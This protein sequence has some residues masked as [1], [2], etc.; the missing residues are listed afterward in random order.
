MLAFL[1][2]THRPVKRT[3]YAHLRQVL[4]GIT[5]GA[6]A[7][8]RDMALRCVADL[9]AINAALESALES[10]IRAN[11]GARHSV[12]ERERKAQE[13]DRKTA[14]LQV[15]GRAHLRWWMWWWW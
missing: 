8:S 11:D 13:Q 2:D 3:R 6:V 1:T 5:P 12:E 15:Y 4:A 7:V 10:E 14:E 9:E